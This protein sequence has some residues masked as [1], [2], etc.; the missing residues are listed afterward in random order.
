MAKETSTGL[1]VPGVL[2][3]V[4]VVL[5]LTDTIDWSWFWV[6]SPIWYVLFLHAMCWIYFQ[7][8]DIREQR[9]KTKELIERYA[10]EDKIRWR[11]K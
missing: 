6:L 5:K 11:I 4:F 7:V 8:I 10:Q 3:I 1:G 9:K 2:L